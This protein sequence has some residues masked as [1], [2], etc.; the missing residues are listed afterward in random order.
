MRGGGGGT[1]AA[2]VCHDPCD[3]GTA[4]PSQWRRQHSGGTVTAAPL[5]QGRQWHAAAPSQWGAWWRHS[6]HLAAVELLVLQVADPERGQHVVV[7]QHFLW[8]EGCDTPH[9]ADTGQA[10]PRHDTTRHGMAQAQHSTAQHSTAW[11]RI[12]RHSATGRDTVRHGTPRHAT[13]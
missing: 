6:T 12:A 3:L 5:S 10:A 7:G 8:T 1:V 4:V 9:T 11:H 2:V 13:T